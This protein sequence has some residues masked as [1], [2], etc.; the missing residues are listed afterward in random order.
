MILVN[1]SIAQN[2]A[3]SAPATQN[4]RIK[5]LNA[6]FI[7]ALIGDGKG[8][9]WI[10]TEDNGIFHCSSDNIVKN[11]TTKNGRCCQMKHRFFNFL[12]L[13]NYDNKKLT[14][15]FTIFLKTRFY[16]TSFPT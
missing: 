15:P 8:G 16:Q 2:T 5:G 13:N 6:R 7:V 12:L 10:G 1:I 11:Y 4:Q 3:Q 9:A 14:E